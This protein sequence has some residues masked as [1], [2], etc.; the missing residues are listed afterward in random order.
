MHQLGL[1][2]YYPT[3][4]S[5]TYHKIYFGDCREILP[6]I[7]SESIDLIFADPPYNMSKKK[8]LG[9]KYSKHVTMQEEWDMFSKDD[10]FQFNK[11]WLKEALRVLKHGGSLWIS[12]SFHNIY[13]V[14][15]ILQHI[16]EV[17]INNSI[18]WF[19]PNAQP[20]I[21]CRMFTESTEHLIWASKNGKGKRWTFNYEDTK[22]KIVDPWS[23]KGKQ[24]RNVWSIPLTSKK[25][26]W[27]GPHPTQKPEELLRR[28]ILA[29]SNKGE[30]VLDPFVGSG[31]TS[32]VAKS[33]GR[34]SIGIEK[35]R[36]NLDIIKK[37]LGQEILEMEG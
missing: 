17:K 2:P 28:I 25:E 16:E 13:Q 34:N 30:T 18:V 14:G 37:R 21:T 23:P 12:G 32:V 6:K 35:D 5:K 8:G 19:K 31:T 7:P 22:N 9:W 24:A 36:K 27:A 4:S 26:K 3:Y 10:Y 29:C 33:L 15:F 1:L 11:N 20:N